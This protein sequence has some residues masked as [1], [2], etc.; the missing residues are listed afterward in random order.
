[1]SDR[2]PLPEQ[3]HAD[4]FLSV[5]IILASIVKYG[6][7][8]IAP[9]RAVLLFVNACYTHAAFEAGNEDMKLS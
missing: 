6:I 5:A 2:V 7:L 3:L 4:Q 8:K 1:M 9:G